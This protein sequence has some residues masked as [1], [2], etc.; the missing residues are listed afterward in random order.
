MLLIHFKLILQFFQIPFLIVPSYLLQ[1]RFRF[2]SNSFRNSRKKI[3][4]S[5]LQVFNKMSFCQ[6]FCKI[7]MK[8]NVAESPFCMITGLQPSASFKKRPWNRFFPLSF[9]KFLNF[10]FLTHVVESLFIKVACLQLATLS[11]KRLQCRC[12]ILDF[13]SFLIHFK[14]QKQSFAGVLQNRFSLKLFKT[15]RKIPVTESLLSKVKGLQ[16]ATL[17]EKKT[18]A[19]VFYSGFC[20]VIQNMFFT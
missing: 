1:I 9:A 13:V 17:I 16:P 12:F 10:T 11:E 6:I 14:F 2:A 7:Q 5:C 19:K 18:L 8:T 3:R 15:Q 20:K 4:N